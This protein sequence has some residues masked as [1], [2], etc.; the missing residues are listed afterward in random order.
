M[1]QSLTTLTETTSIMPTL[2]RQS[3]ES[4]SL[5]NKFA[6]EN[7]LIIIHYTTLNSWLKTESSAKFKLRFQI[8]RVTPNFY[9][10]L[11]EAK[12]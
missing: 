11:V 1:H 4:K 2:C 6:H 10:N 9:F 5:L 7:M 8:A 3:R 12:H